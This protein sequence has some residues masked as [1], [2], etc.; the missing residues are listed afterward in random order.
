[1]GNHQKV[2]KDKKNKKVFQKERIEMEKRQGK[3]INKQSKGHHR[4]VAIFRKICNLKLN[5]LRIT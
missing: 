2:N 1:M 4:K 3:E 5:G